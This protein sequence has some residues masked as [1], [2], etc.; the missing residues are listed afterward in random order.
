MPL[1]LIHETAPDWF[2]DVVISP[3][4]ILGRAVIEL[5]SGVGTIEVSLCIRGQDDVITVRE[6][7]PG[8]RYPATCHERHIQSDHNFC[9]GVKAGEGIT[10]RDH[11]VVW[12]G[13]LEKYLRLQRVAERTRRWPA[14]QEIAH[15]DAGLH[16]LAA[17]QAARQLGL[18]DDYMRML[19]GERKWFASPWPKVDERQK[20]RNG[21][22]PC[23]AGCRRNGKAI[24]RI[25]CCSRD[26]VVTLLKEERLRR[27]A[28]ERFWRVSLA[29]GEECC[30]TMLKCPLQDRNIPRNPVP[31]T[32]AS[33]PRSRI[34]MLRR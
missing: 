8:T 16:Q 20:L 19:E 11:A 7:V 26:P 1:R 27:K 14:Q 12:W 32:G 21:R 10:T 15:G 13:L 4:D 18:E 29:L 22:A 33:K 5:E 34:R 25:D 31:A 30:G 9:I 28:I 2:Q 24:L 17:L 6:R 3:Q 23:P